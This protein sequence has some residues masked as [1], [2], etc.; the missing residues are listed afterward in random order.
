M[1]VVFNFMNEYEPAQR[2]AFKHGLVDLL[3]KTL[4][5]QDKTPTPAIEYAL[6]CLELV[7]Q[8]DLPL[9]DE[10]GELI[11]S[12]LDWATYPP[13]QFD[14]FHIILSCLSALHK[15]EYTKAFSSD[16]SPILHYV[17]LMAR[18]QYWE[19]K[20]AQDPE[21]V[22]DEFDSD[23]VARLIRGARSSTIATISEISASESF[24]NQ[25]P[26]GLAFLDSIFELLASSDPNFL[27]C[28][29]L[30][31]GNVA[32][33][34]EACNALV[35]KY[36]L[37]LSLVNVLKEQTQIGVLHAAG[38][39]LKNLVIGSPAIRE[40]VVQ[41]GI[42]QYCHKFYL[43]SVMIE[44]QHMGLSLVRILVAKSRENVECL[45]L[46]FEGDSG[47][48]AIEQILELYAQNTETPIRMEIGRIV[49]SILRE[50]AKPQSADSTKV[51]LQQKIFDMSPRILEPVIDMVIQDKWPVIASEGWFA[52]ALCVQ[53]TSGADAVADLTFSEVF[54]Q[55]LRRAIARTDDTSSTLELTP[56]EESHLGPSAL[57][58]KA[59]TQ[60]QKDKEN[61][62]MFL[63][64]FLNHNI[65]KKSQPYTTLFRWF[66]D[67][68][69]VTDA[70]IKET[71]GLN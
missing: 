20:L 7:L 25:Y 28:A 1:V 2:H 14:I 56:L 16:P 46:P 45:L 40:P 6:R 62:Y 65:S 36:R 48:S 30:I 60:F 19:D 61:V 64:G 47:S 52:L 35:H 32:R 39:A 29:A 55:V 41:G 70:Q 66:L 43:A 27:T 8:L 18:L 10:A 50:A 51:S 44:V 17:K 57:D 71:L 68:Q 54:F 42:L 53:T 59:N 5:E 31:L 22:P 9:G 63:S 69:E 67:G 37:H 23:D 12:L 33:D 21:L 38:G 11:T 49:V 26:V 3:A 4:R 15:Q 13:I 34:A 58:S 24:Q